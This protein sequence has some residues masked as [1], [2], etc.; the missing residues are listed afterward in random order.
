MNIQIRYANPS[1]AITTTKI[2]MYSWLSAYDHIFGKPAIIE[3][4]ENKL[5]DVNYKKATKK[6]ILNKKMFVACDDGKPVGMMVIDKPKY[7]MKI[8]EV[9]ALYVLP[10]YQRFG[11]GKMLMNKA[12]DIAK[13]HNIKKLNWFALKDNV[14]G[15]AFYQKI[16][17][18]IVSTTIQKVCGT[19]AE[20]VEYHLNI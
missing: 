4:F 19:D 11:I 6:I 1:E 14:I 5:N 12:F 8:M 10:D 2:R 16:G 9:H 18:K 15:N 20:L 7:G 17:G 13:L 3:N